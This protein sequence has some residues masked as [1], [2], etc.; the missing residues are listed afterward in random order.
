MLRVPT[1]RALE[2]TLRIRTVLLEMREPLYR[3]RLF[4]DKGGKSEM[5]KLRGRAHR[6]LL[7]MSVI[8][9]R[10]NYPSAKH[11]PYAKYKHEN[12][13]LNS[14]SSTQLLD[15]SKPLHT[16]IKSTIQNH[17]TTPDINAISAQLVTLIPLME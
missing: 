15:K 12:P 6:E 13:A 7:Q 3:Q 2:P 1:F 8:H 11:I 14:H 4:E 16:S 10:K 9:Q 5:R 17:T